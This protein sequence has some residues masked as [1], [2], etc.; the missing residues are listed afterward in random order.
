MASL[1]Q[2]RFKTSKDEKS[3]QRRETSDFESYLA[4]TWV[5]K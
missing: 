4:K 1:R 3:L 2:Y 5:V